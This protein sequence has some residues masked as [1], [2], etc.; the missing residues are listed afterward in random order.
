MPFAAATVSL[1]D[2]R[3]DARTKNSNSSSDAGDRFAE[4][5]STSHLPFSARPNT[6]LPRA[7]GVYTIAFGTT[8]RAPPTGSRGRRWAW[9]FLERRRLMT[10]WLGRRGLIGKW[11]YGYGTYALDL[12]WLFFYWPTYNTLWIPIDTLQPT[13]ELL[14]SLRHL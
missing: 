9:R 3:V 12:V 10:I 11:G 1:S 6:V 5:S 13:G 7:R 8:W 2:R 14:S 4:Y